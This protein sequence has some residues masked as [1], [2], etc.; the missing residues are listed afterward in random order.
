M[1]NIRC[2]IFYA[3]GRSLSHCVKC[4]VI[5]DR[6]ERKLW[7]LKKSWESCWEHI[8]TSNLI[9]S[10]NARKSHRVSR[11]YEHSSNN[12]VMKVVERSLLAFLWIYDAAD[13]FTMNTYDNFSSMTW[14]GM[15]THARNRTHTTLH[16]GC[17]CRCSIYQRV[18]K[19]LRISM[20]LIFGLATVLI[21]IYL[22]FIE[23][24]FKQRKSLSY[25]SQ[26]L[27]RSPSSYVSIGISCRS[28]IVDEPAQR[29]SDLHVLLIEK[30]DIERGF[31]FWRWFK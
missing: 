9:T 31:F 22:P 10:W 7:R 17:Q 15:I 5:L 11:L 3:S 19:Y 18:S 27:C 30:H 23:T 4:Y 21:N 8:N 12:E 28:Y 6:S 24:A 16:V 20:I 29:T 26:A 14:Q 1:I 25:L 13:W 2:F